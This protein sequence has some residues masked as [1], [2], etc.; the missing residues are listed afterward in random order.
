MSE[1]DRENEDVFQIVH[2]NP[3]RRGVIR[4]VGYIVNR[5]VAERFAAYEAAQKRRGGDWVGPVV[6]IL[7][8][9]AVI[10]MTVATVI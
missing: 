2:D 8:T 5:D 7:G 9:I 3:R 4:D 6:M 1:F 10:A